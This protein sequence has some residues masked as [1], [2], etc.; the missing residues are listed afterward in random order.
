M[1]LRDTRFWAVFIAIAFVLLWCVSI[2]VTYAA[3]TQEPLPEPIEAVTS[4]GVHMI[5]VMG[6]GLVGLGF[7]G[8]A[9]AVLI[10]SSRP[11]RKR[12]T[13]RAVSSPRSPYK[14]MHSVYTPAPTRRY[15][16]NI[17][18]RY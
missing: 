5:G 17:E 13:V 16:R 12:R 1:K 18:R 4:P 7:A 10:N 11:K 9:L 15:Q 6:W 3:P 14:V 2:G 8:V